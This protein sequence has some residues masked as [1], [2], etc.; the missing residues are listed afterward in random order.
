MDHKKE[1]QEQYKEIPIE[2]GIYSITNNKNGKVY[3]GALNNLKR[4]NGVQFQLKLGTYMN[5]IV[6]KEWQEFGED[7]FVIA[8]NETLKKPTS[9][10][11]DV[12]KE[13]AKREVY[14]IEKIKPVYNQK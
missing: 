11:Y 1:L 14:W 3:I 6:Q 4:L 2:A 12:K 13:L 8:V 10:N 7:N 5:K 9:G